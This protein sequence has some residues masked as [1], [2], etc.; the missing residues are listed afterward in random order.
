MKVELVAVTQ[1]A[2]NQTLE[3]FLAYCGRICTKTVD[4][5]NNTNDARFLKAR[6]TQGHESILEHASASFL[7]AQVSR[8]CLAQLTRHRLSSFSVESMRYAK[9]QDIYSTTFPES[10]SSGFSYDIYTGAI[11]TAQQAYDALVNEGIPK[12]DA[13]MVLPLG[14]HTTLVMTSNFRQ[15][16]TFLK[17]RL[18]PAAQWEVRAV[19]NKIL[20]LLNEHAPNVFKDLNNDPHDSLN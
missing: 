3:A 13:R 1:P 19:A 12:E 4:R 5:I 20:F 16:R 15:W 11:E 14:V 9:D 17:Q 18:Q 7:I 10:L 8:T 2:A 6:I